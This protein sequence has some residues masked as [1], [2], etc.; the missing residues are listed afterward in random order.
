[1]SQA[2]PDRVDA[3]QSRTGQ[4]ESE[5]T[6]FDRLHKLRVILPAMAEE[7]ATARREAVRLRAENARLARRVAE[8]ELLVSV[9][10]PAQPT[11]RLGALS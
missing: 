3:L 1:M 2:P 10:T 5:R 8:L 6:V 11:E 7:A 4:M 9:G